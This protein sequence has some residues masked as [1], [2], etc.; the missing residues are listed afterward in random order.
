MKKEI[1]A[2]AMQQLWDK[3]RRKVS[4]VQSKLP[5]GAGPSVVNDDFGDML[6]V[7]Y[8]LSSDTRTYCFIERPGLTD[9]LVTGKVRL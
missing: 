4:D 9:A 5:A 3:L 8:I 7:F 6:G 1:R 2:D